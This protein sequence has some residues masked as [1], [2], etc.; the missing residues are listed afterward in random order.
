[1]QNAYITYNEEGLGL[2][3]TAS[4]IGAAGGLFQG[5]IGGIFGNKIA[6]INNNA[7]KFA[8]D[9]KRELS[10]D[11][12]SLSKIQSETQKL[13]QQNELIK[14]QLLARNNQF[15]MQLQNEQNK[16]KADTVLM[17]TRL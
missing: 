11:A 9:T 15:G 2:F 10:K 4:L 12:L 3:P 1:M 13:A 17:K 5:V 7:L 8:E 16:A 6:K 14:N